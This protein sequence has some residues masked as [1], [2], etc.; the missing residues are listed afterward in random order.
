VIVFSIKEPSRTEGSPAQIAPVKGAWRLLGA[1]FRWFLFAIFIFTLG[2]STDAF[3][4]LR[5]NQTGVHPAWTA[6]LWSAFHIVKMLAS[7]FGGLLSDKIGRKPSIALGWGLYAIV[8]I[9]FALLENLMSLIVVFLIYGLYFGLTESSEKAWVSELAPKSIHGAA[10]G[11]YNGVIGLG[12]LPASVIFGLVWKLW[13]ADTAF[14][15]GALLS[16][17]AIIILMRV[18]AR[19]IEGR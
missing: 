7:Y 18:K 19:R 10:F 16:V 4:L 14:F 2:N 9:S 15:F 6:I 8:Y 11:L 5:L 17:F 13:G 12:A 1:N 3:L